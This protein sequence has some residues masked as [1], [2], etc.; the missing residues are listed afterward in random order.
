MAEQLVGISAEYIFFCAYL[1]RDHPGEAA[2]VN[3][4]MLANFLKAL[5]LTGAAKQ[6]KRFVLTC[7]L[8]HYGAGLGRP[9]QPM[10]ESDPLL[11]NGVG[12]VANWPSNFYYTQ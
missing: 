1:A 8:G 2:R 6:L 4:A 11:E 12:G 10:L 9:K 5:E 3:G 7:G